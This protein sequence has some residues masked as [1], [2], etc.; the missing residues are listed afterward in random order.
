MRQ[1]NVI[2]Q[3]NPIA[4][5][6]TTVIIQAALVASKAASERIKEVI[7]KAIRAEYYFGEDIEVDPIVLANIQARTIEDSTTEDAMDEQDGDHPMDVGA[8]HPRGDIEPEVLTMHRIT[9]VPGVGT[10]GD[11]AV[12]TY[13]RDS[14]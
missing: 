9:I 12:Q 11:T 14:Q 6:T 3:K 2:I 5:E 10:V 4:I 8:D 13:I 7:R 1:F